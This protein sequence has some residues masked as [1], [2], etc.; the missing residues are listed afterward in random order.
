MNNLI[1]DDVSYIIL[2]LGLTIFIVFFGGHNNQHKIE[3]ENFQWNNMDLLNFLNINHL[4]NDVE[5]LK[6]YNFFNDEYYKISDKIILTENFLPNFVDCYLIKIK[7]YDFF[8][9]SKIISNKDL[10]NNLMILI[11]QENKHNSTNLELL[12]NTKNN[13]GYFYKLEKKISILSI[14]DIFN[15]SNQINLIY[16]IIVKKPYWF[17]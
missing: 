12:I 9:I 7:P 10:A 17:H 11:G 2:V 3:Y 8:N 6:K 1:M 16:C 5:N 15:N 13:Y 14:Y 4:I